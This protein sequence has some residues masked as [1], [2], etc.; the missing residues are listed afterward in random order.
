MLIDGFEQFTV[1]QTIFLGSIPESSE[2][3]VEKH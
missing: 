1:N 3:I 2:W